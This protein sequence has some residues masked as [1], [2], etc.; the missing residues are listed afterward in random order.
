MCLLVPFLL[1]KYWIKLYQKL[2]DRWRTAQKVCFGYR[3]PDGRALGVSCRLPFF[4]RAADSHILFPSSSGMSVSSLS[5]EEPSRNNG[6]G[7]SIACH[8]I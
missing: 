2:R 5:T 6:I 7:P 4:P 8:P 1:L 3:V